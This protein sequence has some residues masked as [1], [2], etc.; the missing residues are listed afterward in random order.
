MRRAWILWMALASLGAAAVP[1]APTAKKETRAFSVLLPG[2]YSCEVRGMICTACAGE[3]VE[4]LKA[5]AGV[6][7]ARVDFDRR[8]LLLTV[9]QDKA[10]PVVALRRA[11][12]RAA[13]RIDL[14][15]SFTVGK[16]EYIP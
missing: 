14:G 12:Q 7:S 2:V 10:V 9:A 11:L 3:I 6:E 13:R 4:S 8:L 16:I 5:V 1:Q 15:T